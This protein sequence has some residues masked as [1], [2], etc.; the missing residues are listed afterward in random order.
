[1]SRASTGANATECPVTTFQAAMARYA[2]GK[3]MQDHLR[4]H[5]FFREVPELIRTDWALMASPFC[6]RHRA[7]GCR[8]A[9]Q[10]HE[11]VC[12][13]RRTRVAPAPSQWRFGDSLFSV[14]WGAWERVRE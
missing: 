5:H 9:L 14:D 6:D 7:R 4:R 10:A 8:T 3:A 13:L 11:V 2:T 12:Q 1:M